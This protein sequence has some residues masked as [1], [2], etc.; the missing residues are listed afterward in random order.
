[1]YE[2]L[3]ERFTKRAQK[4][5]QLAKQEAKRF[6][7]ENIGTEHILLGLVNEGTGVAALA[8]KNLG[9]DLRKIRL[10]TEKILRLI[11][12][13]VTFS[14]VPQIPRVNKVIEYSMDE[15]RHLNHNYVGTEHI[16]LGLIRE[17][18]CV[19]TQVLMN[20]GLQLEDV[21]KEIIHLLGGSMEISKSN[22]PRV[23]TPQRAN[24]ARRFGRWL[25]SW[26]VPS[27]P[28]A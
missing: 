24:L 20:L 9:T 28:A 17:Q 8:L 26:I 16:L 21:R 18:N 4:V 14:N 1:M 11:P 23:L 7:C 6:N 10:E 13:Y 27:P 25:R 12:H 5:W 3:H 2:Q 22:V 19:A 15:A